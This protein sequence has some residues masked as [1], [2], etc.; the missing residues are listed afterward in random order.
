MQIVD[1]N[2]HRFAEVLGIDEPQPRFAWKLASDTPGDRQTAWRIIVARTLSDVNAGRGPI[3]DSGQV[4]DDR[5]RDLAYT[6]ET[7]LASVTAHWWR[8][9]VWDAAGAAHW[10][11]A[12]FFH[13]AYFHSTHALPLSPN[14]DIMPDDSLF[15]RSYFQTEE[16]HW[17]GRWIGDADGSGKPYY[18]R[19][20]VELGES[21]VRA[22]AFVT[23]L[24]HFDFFVNGEKIS[25]HRL[26]PG[27]TEYRETVQFVSFDVTDALAAGPNVLAAHLGNGFYSGDPGGRF[28]WPLYEDKT[29]VPYAN[30]LPF[31]AEVHLT[32]S[33]GRRE[34]IGSDRSWKTRRSA[35]LLANV[36]ASE[37]HDRRLYP[38]GWNAAGFD[39]SDWPEAVY[40]P[41][42]RGKLRYQ[43]QPPIVVIETHEA[44]AVAEPAPGTVVFDLGQNMSGIFEVFV[45]GER[46]ATITIRYGETIYPDGRIRMPDPNFGVWE[47]QAYSTF[48]LEGTGEPESWQPDFSYVGARWVQVEGVSRDPN[49]S[50]PWIETVRGHFVSSAS[51]SVGRMETDRDDV[52]RLLHVL[53]KTFESNLQSLHTDCPQLEKLGWLEVTHLLAPAT[54]YIKDVEDLYS[55]IVFDMIDSQDSDGLVPT[56]APEIRYMTGPFRDSLPWGIAI[57]VLPRILRDYYDSTGIIEKAYP[58]MKR[59]IDYIATREKLGGLIDHGLGDWGIRGAYGDSAFNLE[60]GLYIYGVRL[61]AQFAAALGKDDDAAYY[62]G[63]A[64]RLLEVYNG[65]LLRRLPSGRFGY[66]AI[67]L[68]GEPRVTAVNQALPLDLGLVPDEHRADVETAFLE[69]TEPGVIVSGEIGL[70]YLLNQLGELGRNDTV[71]R[72]ARQ[73]EHPSYMRFLEMGETT[74]PEFWDDNARSK[75]HDMMGHILEWFYAHVLGVTSLEAGYKRIGIAPDYDGEFDRIEGAFDSPRGPIEVRMRRADGVFELDVTV[76]VNATAMLSRPRGLAPIHLESGRHSYVF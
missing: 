8:V 31:L 47:Q 55:K 11:E 3:W 34:V 73:K 22:I 45:R 25:N 51:A 41:G 61:V 14:L 21:P 24:G 60:T 65:T 75:N 44:V 15:F 57:V 16:P 46:G 72:M 74:L 19:R 13:T 1:L 29:Y 43:S 49:G 64:D 37:I 28:F 5:Q 42:P 68:P 2:I 59:Y 9:Q 35:T 26:D 4:H 52:N 6:S 62:E 10:S 12:M 7:P 63:K 67:D 38:H 56:M 36:Y 54:Q 39:D 17:L 50:L 58:A 66:V 33:D 40:L 20:Q 71:L 30:D 48:I 70:R 27:W 32:Y 53:T 23:G 76:P 69:S 18:V